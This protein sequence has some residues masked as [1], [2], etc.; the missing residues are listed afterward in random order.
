MALVAG[1][2]S[3]IPWSFTAPRWDI[4]ENNLLRVK[5]ALAC[6]GRSISEKGAQAVASHFNAAPCNLRVLHLGIEIPYLTRPQ[7]PRADAMELRV[8]TAADFVEVKGHRHL[9][10]ALPI[11]EARGLVVRV[12]LVGDG[13]LRRG[14]ERHVEEAGLSDSVT[15]L[16][17]VSHAQ[18]LEDFRAHRW[19]ALVLPS[20]VTERDEEGIP[21]SVMEAMGA[22]LPVISTRTGAIPELLGDRDGVLVAAGDSV[23]LADALEVLARDPD[24]RQRLAEKGR[25]RVANDFN[26]RVVASALAQCF[27][28]CATSNS[29]RRE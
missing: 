4:A 8:V 26:V 2:V 6:F 9:L 22:G 11:L 23:A 20:V 5:L 3:R 28:E 18:L 21:V 19:D 29:V 1:E 10:Q 7:R 25:R 24:F 15:L 16:G 17:T 27:E 13:P 14:L 12:D